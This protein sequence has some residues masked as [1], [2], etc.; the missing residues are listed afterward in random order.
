MQ[1]YTV[2]AARTTGEWLD[3]P[4]LIGEVDKSEWDKMTD[5]D[6]LHF[7]T[8]EKFDKDE[9]GNEP[10]TGETCAIEVSWVD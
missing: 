3:E 9:Q 7:D 4:S 10:V 1:K 6:D 5:T 2:E 8:F